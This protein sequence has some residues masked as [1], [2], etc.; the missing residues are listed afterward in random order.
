[1]SAAAQE[2]FSLLS[3]AGW[4]VPLAALV[5]FVLVA[6]SGSNLHLFLRLNAL[7]PATSD[8]LWANIT[9]LGDTVTALALCLPLWRRRPDLLWALALGGLLASAWVHGLKPWLDIARP[10]A[11]LGD[12]VHLIGPT[13]AARSFPSGHATTAFFV[14]GLLALGLG[15][16]L[17]FAAALLVALAAAASRSVVGVHWPLDVLGGAFGGWLAA[18]AGLAL[19]QRFPAPAQSPWIQGL[20]GLSLTG[21]AVALLAGHDGG[22]PQAGWFLRGIAVATLATAGLALWR[23]HSIG[24]HS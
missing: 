4:L 13:L 22:Y 19:G 1:V 8:G 11:V 24:R 20:L 7:G 10:S 5:A 23:E 6:V 2:D 17:A 15:S 3:P 18:A 9:V 21:C 16:R 14:A 12:A